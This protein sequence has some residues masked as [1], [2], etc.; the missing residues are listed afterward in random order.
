MLASDQLER[1]RRA[2][3]DARSGPQLA[4][5]VERVR[6][7]RYEIAAHESLKSAPRGYPKDHP[8]IEL[9]RSKGL[10]VGRTFAPALWLHARPALDRIVTVWRDAAA[11]NRWLD[12]NVGPSTL[13]P[14]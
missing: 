3:A 8:R 14:G 11:V 2:V 4:R 1:W 9:L 12:R 7:Q 10:T 13:P 5:E 6:A